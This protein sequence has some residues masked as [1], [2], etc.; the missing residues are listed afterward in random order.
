MRQRLDDH[1]ASPLKVQSP[2][3][4]RQ[5]SSSSIAFASVGADQFK[6]AAVMRAASKKDAMLCRK[7]SKSNLARIQSIESNSS[8]HNVRRNSKIFTVSND[9]TE[10]ADGAALKQSPSQSRMDKGQLS[11]PYLAHKWGL[12]LENLK[13]SAEIFKQ[14]AVLP[15]SNKDGDMFRNGQLSYDE[16]MEIVVKMTGVSSI[17]DLP[18]DMRKEIQKEADRNCDGIVDFKEFALWYHHRAF[19][20]Y[21][22]L[23]KPERQMREVASRLGISCADMDHYKAMF[24]KHD[25]N[26]NGVIEFEEFGA[27]MHSLMRVPPHLHL[28]SSRIM[29]FWNECDTD[30]DGWV[31]LSEFVHFYTKHFDVDSTNPMENFYRG[32]RRV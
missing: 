30:G 7:E 8:G 15:P 25:N 14:Y 31:D 18:E 1:S 4:R 23:S 10:G 32:I 28:S 29:H 21:V 27:L 19:M 9:D 16:L 5:C 11:L 6:E 13:G 24:S 22:N 2:L 12:P 26:G 20:T 17:A 3:R